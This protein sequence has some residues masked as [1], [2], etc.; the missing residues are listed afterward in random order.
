MAASTQLQGPV[1]RLSQPQAQA[2]AYMQARPW[3]ALP[4]GLSALIRA[5]NVRLVPE[6]VQEIRRQIPEY[7]RP[8]DGRFGVGIQQGAARA[9]AQFAELVADDRAC[10]EE[11]LQ[12]YRALG[13]GEWREGRSLDALQAAYRLGARLAWRRYARLA[14]RAGVPAVAMTALAEAIFAHIDEMAAASVEGYA[15]ARA[16]AAGTLRR[17]R[18]RLVQLLVGGAAEPVLTECSRA[19]R[20]PLPERIAAV[21][22]RTDGLL[23]AAAGLRTMPSVLAD[24]EGQGQEPCLFLAD[25]ELP[26]RVEQLAAVL[27]DRTA[28]LGPAVPVV[29]AAQSL[30]WA[31]TVA[32]RLPADAEPGLVHC[33]N[34]LSSVLLLGDEDL[35]KLLAARRLA[36]LEGL[37]GKRRER[38]E[39]TLLAWLETS[40]G[41]APEVAARLGLHPQ[42]V[43]QRMR[44][45]DELFGEALSDPDARFEIELALRGRRLQAR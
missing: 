23:G 43:R 21:A 11:S 13:R 33:D 10:P 22:L 45:I 8:L 19:A 18:R 7:A 9:V 35:V 3:A 36:P 32:A 6:I 37:T 28:V 14:R 4:S 1:R 25:P 16:D 15:E 26:G 39:E 41:S 24:L 40:S 29:Q 17:A 2:R 34:Q 20:Y 38:L 42:T 12:V 27:A 31:R 30:R 44:G 5:E